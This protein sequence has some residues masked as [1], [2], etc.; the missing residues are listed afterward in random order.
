MRI[1]SVQ[2]PPFK[3]ASHDPTPGRHI[4]I[5]LNSGAVTCTRSA[6]F[7]RPIFGRTSRS[8]V[9]AHSL[10][11]EEE[12]PRLPEKFVRCFYRAVVKHVAIH[13]DLVLS[14]Q[15]RQGKRGE[16]YLRVKEFPIGQSR[17]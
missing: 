10:G 4:F 15:H 2:A 3:F 14:C 5:F 11:Q 17:H 9:I 12:L 16:K 8:I 7:S 13:A 6:S 1:D